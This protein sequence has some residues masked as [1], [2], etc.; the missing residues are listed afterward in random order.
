MSN[1]RFITTPGGEELAILPRRDLEDLMDATRHERALAAHR[2]GRD[3]G[4]TAEDMRALLAAATPL[5]FW[6]RKHGLTQGAL[7]KAAGISQNYLSSLETG[8]RSG[9]LQLWARIA[10]ALDV[11]LDGLVDES[12]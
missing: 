7:A 8:K 11:A 12:E 2:T 1:V 5:A 6:R 3:P 9:D 4:L 10:R